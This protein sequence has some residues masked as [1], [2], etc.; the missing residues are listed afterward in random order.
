MTT[1]EFSWGTGKWVAPKEKNILNNIDQN[2]LSSCQLPPNIIAR[3]ILKAYSGQ[4]VIISYD[5]IDGCSGY[6][7]NRHDIL[8]INGQVEAGYLINH[9]NTDHIEIDTDYGSFIIQR[10]YVWNN[11][12][13]EIR[14]DSR[15]S[16]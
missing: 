4:K 10:L 14:F 5:S 1:R 13:T 12:T 15:I 11:S 9:R 6:E 16:S 2:V 3:N 8:K 7:Q